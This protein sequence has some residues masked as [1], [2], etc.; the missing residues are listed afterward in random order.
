MGAIGLLLESATVGTVAGVLG[1]LALT[2]AFRRFLV[3]DNL[4][5]VCTLSVGLLLF[6]VSNHLVDESG[7][8]AVTVMGI[9]LSNQTHFDVEHLIEFK[10]N[11]RTLLIGCLFI[12][13]GSRV[14]FSEILEIGL[15]GIVFLLL[16]IVLVRPVSVMFGL[17]GTPFTLK[18]KVFVAALA[19]RGIVAA[20]I[21]SA[22][23]LKMEPIAA[24]LGIPDAHQLDTV[25]F[26]VIVG[27]VTTYGLIASPLAKRLGLA[28]D[29]P[30][31]L[32]IAG[33]DPWIRDF[34]RTL[35]EAGIPVR[36]VD[37][38]FNNVATAKMS[39]LDAI[40]GN[41]LN[42]Y[43][44]DDLPLEGIGKF[45]A[46][47][48]NDEVNSLAMR[49]YRTLF[50]RVQL[51]QLSFNSEKLNHRRG[52]T[53]N[54]MGRELFAKGLTHSLIRDRHAR[55]AVFKVTTLSEKFTYS[56]FQSRHGALATLLCVLDVNQKLSIATTDRK[57][58]PVPGDRVI[59]LIE[60][61]DGILVG[62][63]A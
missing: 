48:S 47:T 30:N 21:S 43:V 55:G 3:P 34:A 44:R 45:L 8:I 20:A 4:Q 35:G 25:T 19:P 23:A 53:S 41:I 7:L 58:T 52:L 37:T 5:G 56:D 57:L 22:F 60:P 50:D 12:V 11:L 29:N 40:C 15:P 18:E 2:S 6:A 16:L 9:W 14:K 59:A 51:F 10:E 17:W 24:S 33:A 42:E 63:D 1:G 54:L 49:E 46:M 38:N 13:L 62:N 61:T 32:L 27:T 28:D 31:G 26:L 39:G 36:L